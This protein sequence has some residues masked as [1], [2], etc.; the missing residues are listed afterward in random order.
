MNREI[1]FRVWEKEQFGPHEREMYYVTLNELLFSDGYY[2]SSLGEEVDD[3]IVMQYTGLHDKNGKEIYEGDVVKANIRHKDIEI[4]GRV[5]MPKSCWVVT[6][7]NP[8][9]GYYNNRRTAEFNELEI[10]GNIYENPNLLK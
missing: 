5:H 10:L 3:N 4:I 8:L 9:N 7:K 1:K 2:L 6:F